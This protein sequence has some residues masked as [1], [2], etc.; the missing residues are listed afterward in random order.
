LKTALPTLLL[1]VALLP[2]ASAQAQ[3]FGQFTGAKPLDVNGHLSGAYVQSSL[4]LLGL[5]GQLRLSFYPGVDFGFQGG[6]DRQDY[7]G[8][9]RTNLRLGADFKYAMLNPSD[10]Y[11]YSLA[12]GGALGVE[13]GD[14]FTILSIAPMMVGSRTLATG[15]TVT[16]TPY[17]A[18]GL[19]FSRINAGG[20]DDT[21]FSVPLFVGASLRL[22]PQ[23]D[24][25]GELQF[26]FGDAYNDDV[27]FSL[28]ANFPF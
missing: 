12:I 11:P 15:Q 5:L 23:V 16:L 10:A 4:N 17:A 9:S 14:N 20:V 3:I 24:L 6:L 22:S 26:R 8:D 1:A 13:T 21:D 25:V 28:G 27:G 2:G 18:T 19:Q 7:D